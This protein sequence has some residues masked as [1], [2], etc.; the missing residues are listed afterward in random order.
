MVARRGNGTGTTSRSEQK[1]SKNLKEELENAE[2]EERRVG[3]WEVGA[4]SEEARS[5][6]PGKSEVSGQGSV[7]GGA[8][9]VER[10]GA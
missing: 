1:R 2:S 7:A 10:H 5:W 4:Q 8:L 9:A 6:K 3:S